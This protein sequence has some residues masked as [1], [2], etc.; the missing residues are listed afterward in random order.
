MNLDKEPWSSYP[1]GPPNKR[2]WEPREIGEGENAV[3]YIVWIE[4]QNQRDKREEVP[5]ADSSNF[6]V[7]E[8]QKI[9]R[10]S[11]LVD[12]CRL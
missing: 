10:D 2:T 7:F 11:K 3:R 12:A 5:K 9:V 4:L 6:L 1:G 8:M